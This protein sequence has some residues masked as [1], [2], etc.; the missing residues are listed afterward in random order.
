MIYPILSSKK[1]GNTKEKTCLKSLFWFFV[2]ER[3]E[4][5]DKGYPGKGEKVYCGI[6]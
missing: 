6:A 1:I 4:K 2:V 5:G 3:K